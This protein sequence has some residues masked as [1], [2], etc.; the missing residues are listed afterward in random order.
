MRLTD[1]NKNI[2]AAA[3]LAFGLIVSAI[4]YA[5]SNRYEIVKS[6]QGGILKVDKWD[7]TAKYLTKGD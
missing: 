4:I 7:G 1:A 3:I 2:I 5:Y 6:S